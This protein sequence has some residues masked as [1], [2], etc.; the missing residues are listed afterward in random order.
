MRK[1]YQIKGNEIIEI[2]CEM[3]PRNPPQWKDS[4]GRVYEDEELFHSKK[5]AA[6][7]IA[8]STFYRIEDGKIREFRGG[9]IEPGEPWIQEQLTGKIYCFDDVFYTLE[10]ATYKKS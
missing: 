8:S 10:N 4:T 3:I 9:F 5:A 6:S 7:F 2:D 1:M